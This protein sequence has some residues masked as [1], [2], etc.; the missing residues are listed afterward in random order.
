MS[1]GLGPSD[2]FADLHGQGKNRYSK[3]HG[4]IHGMICSLRQELLES[5][6]GDRLH[7]VAN[8][9]RPS[10]QPP[11]IQPCNGQPH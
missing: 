9:P 3:F 10:F 5:I 11:Y 4:L 2:P 8:D 6:F 7:V 1:T